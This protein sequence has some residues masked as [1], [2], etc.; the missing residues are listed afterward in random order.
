MDRRPNRAIFGGI[1][2][3][4]NPHLAAEYAWRDALDQPY[5]ERHIWRNV[6]CRDA[7][8]CCI[9]KKP[10]RIDRNW[11]LEIP[12]NSRF[13]KSI[14]AILKAYLQQAEYDEV[15]EANSYRLGRA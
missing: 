9:T 12:T 4:G 14:R 15:V 8:S 7:G 1:V 6:G 13:S 5:Q 11:T 2:A 3:L 10:D